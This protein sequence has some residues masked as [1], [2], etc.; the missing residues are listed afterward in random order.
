MEFVMRITQAVRALVPATAAVATL[1][2]APTVA[3]ATDYWAD[4][5]CLG[6]TNYQHVMT[7]QNV[8]WPIEFEWTIKKNNGRYFEF[9]YNSIA[10]PFHIQQGVTESDTAKIMMPPTGFAD[11]FLWCS[12]PGVIHRNY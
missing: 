9:S 6:L 12:A 7:T 11:I 5:P 1:I 3:H 4:R 8:A 2:T 10:P